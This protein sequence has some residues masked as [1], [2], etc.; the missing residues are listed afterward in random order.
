MKANEVVGDSKVAT[1]SSIEAQ[2]NML[3][4]S[5]NLVNEPSECFKRVKMEMEAERKLLV[6]Q[7][8]SDFGSKYSFDL[9]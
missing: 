3:H 8:F 9:G 6:C 2:L 1:E 4:F 7:E 5:T